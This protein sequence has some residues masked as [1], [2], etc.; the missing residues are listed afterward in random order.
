[1]ATRDTGVVGEAGQSIPGGQV[2]PEPELGHS[3]STPSTRTSKRV[4]RCPKKVEDAAAPAPASAAKKRGGGQK[5]KRQV[6]EAAPALQ[7]EATGNLD[8]PAGPLH[9][10][11]SGK[12]G[13]RGGAWQIGACADF[14]CSASTQCTAA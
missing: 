4:R 11:P 13:S 1:M 10:G 7:L 5:R 14:A 12:T 2:Q 9:V 8:A 3:S 6:T